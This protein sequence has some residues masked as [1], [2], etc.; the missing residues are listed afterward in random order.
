MKMFRKIYQNISYSRNNLFKLNLLINQIW[1]IWFCFS[2]GRLTF[3][4]ETVYPKIVFM[5]KAVTQKCSI[6]TNYP[7][8]SCKVH[9]KPIGIEILFCKVAGQHLQVKLQVSSYKFSEKMSPL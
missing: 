2:F 7:E 8:I 1:Q 4:K 6:K 3:K 9:R 5:S